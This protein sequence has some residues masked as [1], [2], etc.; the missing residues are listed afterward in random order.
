MAIAAGCRQGRTTWPAAL[1]VA[2]QK[3]IG[4]TTTATAWSQVG[5]AG[6]TPCVTAGHA[7][8]IL[9]EGE[10]IVPEDRFVGGFG[11][12]DSPIPAPLLSFSRPLR[13]KLR[14]CPKSTAFCCSSAAGA[15]CPDAPLARS[16]S[17][18]VGALLE[19]LKLISR[20]VRV[21]AVAAATLRLTLTT[22]TRCL[23][24]T[25]PPHPHHHTPPPPSASPPP[26]PPPPLPHHVTPPSPP[27]PFLHHL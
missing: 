10:A 1:M 14:E 2:N 5:R 19:I 18:G 6:R 23:T 9:G 27:P 8:A 16:P 12:T 4:L 21:A 17:G 25:A 24:L 20:V 11:H 7:T 15:H 22:A 3:R 26:P 13:Q